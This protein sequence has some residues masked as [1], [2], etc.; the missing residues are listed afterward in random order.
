M[1]YE[2]KLIT[3]EGNQIMLP[4][5]DSKE[6]PQA[7]KEARLAKGLSRA[8][9]ARLA[10]I[11]PVMPRRYEEPDCGEFARPSASTYQALLR[12]L[13]NKEGLAVDVPSAVSLQEASLEQ[14]VNEL[15]TRG[16]TVSLSFPS[17]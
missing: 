5:P 16:V 12:V 8:A 15:R 11:H 2:V 6:F 13:S 7:L 9:L 17:A 3:S 1:Y 4:L 14:I 10:G